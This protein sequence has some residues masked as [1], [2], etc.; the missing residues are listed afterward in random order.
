M[1]KTILILLTAFVIIG[2]AQT[3]TEKVI[4]TLTFDQADG[5]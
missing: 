1:L 3:T 4:C 2:C 5:C